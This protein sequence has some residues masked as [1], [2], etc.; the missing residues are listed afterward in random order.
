MID[1]DFET[2]NLIQKELQNAPTIKDGKLKGY[3]DVASRVNIFRKYYQ[4]LSL[5]SNLIV[6]TDERVVFQTEV[7]DRE[8][9][10]LAT[11]YAEELRNANYINK[12]SC[13][14][15]CETSSWGRALANYGLAG[16]KIAS[17]DEVKNAV[18]QQSDLQQQN[19]LTISD[20]KAQ[21]ETFTKLEELQRWASKNSIRLNELKKLEADA[22]KDLDKS[23]Q[24][25]EK[26]LKNEKEAKG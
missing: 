14:E 13:L 24:A 23:Y 1:E 6:D 22:Y 9:N 16:Q 10:V 25:K 8:G 18:Q 17:A 5:I 12:T 7:R 26:K 11:G 20:F 21:L 19:K 15:N 4:H 3:I 2:Y